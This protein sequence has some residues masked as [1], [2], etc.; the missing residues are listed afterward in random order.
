MR[1][2]NESVSMGR[3]PVDLA[4]DFGMLALDGALGGMGEAQFEQ[5]R[6]QTRGTQ[7]VVGREFPSTSHEDEP[8]HVKP[9]DPKLTRTGAGGVGC[10]KP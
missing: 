6:S 9:P 3:A 1:K 2:A 7:W 10:K 4:L 5:E 8:T